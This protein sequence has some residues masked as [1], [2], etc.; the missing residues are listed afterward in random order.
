[1][2]KIYIGGTSSAVLLTNSDLYFDSLRFISNNALLILQYD[3]MKKV[4]FENTKKSN[5]K[6]M[7]VRIKMITLEIDGQRHIYTEWTK[8]LFPLMSMHGV[9]IENETDF[10]FE[11]ILFRK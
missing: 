11:R 9:T 1:M 10:S 6:S 2:E 7:K 5:V 8:F 4:L 3:F